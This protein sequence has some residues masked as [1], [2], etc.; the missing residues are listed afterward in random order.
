[1]PD[2]FDLLREYVEKGSD[3]A[4]RMLVER[5]SGMVRAAALRIVRDNGQAQEVTQAVFV[6][7]VRKAAKLRRPSVLAG[8]LYRTAR[9]V[10]MEAL[11]AE[12]R[13]HQ[14]HEDYAQTNATNTSYSVWNQ[15]TPLLDDLMCRL[16]DADRNAI[17][18]RFFE[19][20]PF[21]EVGLALGTTEA[22]AKMRVGRALEKLRAAFAR[23]GVVLPTAA[24]L[25]TLS[26][27]GASA[28][29][30]GLSHSVATI[31]LAGEAASGASVLMLA[32]GALKGMVLSQLKSGLIAAGMAALLVF[33]IVLVE[34][35]VRDGISGGPVSSLEPMAGEWEGT[36][37]SHSDRQATPLKQKVALII[38][39]K[40][41]G[42]SCE[43]EMRISN[44][45]GGETVYHFTHTL[46][47]SGNGIITV[48]DPQIARLSGE[49][50]ISE[51]FSD[52]AA[53]NWRVAFRAPNVNRG[54]YS[55]LRWII[56]KRD[57]LMI[58][59]HDHIR[60]PQGSSE[61]FSKL[62]LHRRALANA[63]C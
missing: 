5:H 39:S 62:K 26:A 42:R 11:R 61:L 24:L 33:S 2:D 10:A 48:D 28:A 21:S 44:G 63:P 18:L 30:A 32:K 59:R 19:D 7:L 54:A 46:N 47:D 6:I 23:R 51:Q 31:A 12:K 9:F 27:H 15:I 4:F 1:M 49:G 25:A 3:D 60:L 55:E 53:G 16:R 56:H 40:Q 52:A 22:G 35:R 36:Y 17:I 41:A 57:E 38:R 43:V 14:H 29:P 50:A 58:D 8:W 20:R 34:P 37:E 13:R 45:T